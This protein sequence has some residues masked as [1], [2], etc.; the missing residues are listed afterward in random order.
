[1][2]ELVCTGP[3]AN[4]GMCVSATVGNECLPVLAIILVISIMLAISCV[5]WHLQLRVL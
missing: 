5:S 1:M 3:C 2:S 4:A